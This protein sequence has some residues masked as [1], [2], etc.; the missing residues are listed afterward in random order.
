MP[1]VAVQALD[2]RV[3]EDLDVA[4]GDPDLPREDDRRIDA[5]DV[6]AP[7]DHRSPPLPFDVLLEFHSQRAV[8]PRRPG[9]AIDLTGRKDE[10]APFGQVHYGVD[11]G[12]HGMVHSLSGFG[13]ARA[14]FGR[15]AQSIRHR[16]DRPRGL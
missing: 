12:R 13:W 7:G 15:G 16:N 14:A 6:V 2:Q 11:D 8:V 5:D 1:V 3:V 4:G 9:A 10:A